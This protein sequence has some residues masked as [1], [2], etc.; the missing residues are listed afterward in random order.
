M[1]RKAFPHRARDPGVRLFQLGGVEWVHCPKCDGAARNGSQ[2]VDCR[3]CGYM[4][5]QKDYPEQRWA[6]LAS[7]DQRCNFCRKPL[8][9]HPRPTAREV[10]GKMLVRVKC[11]NCHETL[12]YPAR[13]AS[14]PTGWKPDAKLR[15]FL[16]A[17]VG[18][19]T[20]WVDNLAHLDALEDYLSALVR[21][22]G[23]VAGLTMMARLPAWMKSASNRPRIVRALRQLRA[24]A[25]KAGIDE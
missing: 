14:P 24:R 19:N 8:D 7:D 9:N 13:Y 4:T 20:L 21:E 17:Q 11:G 23:P 2:G 6:L 22:R 16:T 5:I 10:D 12:D 18:G 25:A 1:T 3:H 15:L